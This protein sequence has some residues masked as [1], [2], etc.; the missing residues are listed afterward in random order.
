M[1][2]H[3]EE[4]SAKRAMESYLENHPQHKEFVDLNQKRNVPYAAI[5]TFLKI[6]PS[7]AQD[8]DIVFQEEIDAVICEM[9]RDKRQIEEGRFAAQKKLKLDPGSTAETTPAVDAYQL[10]LEPFHI[11]TAHGFRQGIQNS[12]PWEF[13]KDLVN[14][15]WVII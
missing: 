13:L 5:A 6:R 7:G 3:D 14:S 2:E 15:V 8:D 9:E 10:N 4:L 11:Q 12:R 1:N